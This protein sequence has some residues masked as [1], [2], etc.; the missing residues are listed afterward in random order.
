MNIPRLMEITQASRD[1]IIARAS[2][3]EITALLLSTE[4]E[5]RK[6]ERE[7]AKMRKALMQ[8]REIN[9]NAC[10]PYEDANKMGKIARAALAVQPDK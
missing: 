3:D 10:D 5:R 2:P 6:L 7:N 8:I 9:V 4:E 1:Q